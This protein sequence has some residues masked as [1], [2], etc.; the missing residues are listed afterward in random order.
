M[1]TIKVI[2]NDKDYQASL[3]RLDSLM[4]AAPDS[5]EAEELDLL[6]YLVDKYES[7]V[8]PV[9]LPDPVEAIMF[10]MEQQGLTQKDLIRY[11]AV[12]YTHLTLPTILRV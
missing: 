11:I 10:R 4:E 1:N 3:V 12:S 9:E 5:P 8:F 2:K 7:E 6:S